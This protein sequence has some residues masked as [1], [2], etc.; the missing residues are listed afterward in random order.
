MCIDELEDTSDITLS[1]FIVHR[2]PPQL[3]LRYQLRPLKV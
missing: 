2:L 3:P 1:L